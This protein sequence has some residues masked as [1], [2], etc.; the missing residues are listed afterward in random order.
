MQREPPPFVWAIPDEKN[1]LTCE[2]LLLPT[3]SPFR[4]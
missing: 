4:S 1:I 3:G 2:F